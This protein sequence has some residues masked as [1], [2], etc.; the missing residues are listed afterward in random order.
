MCSYISLMQ[1]GTVILVSPMFS[2]IIIIVIFNIYQSVL[3]EFSCRT[4]KK[5]T[6]IF[7]VSFPCNG[8]HSS[9]NPFLKKNE[10]N[11]DNIKYTVYR[12][13]FAP[14]YSLRIL[15][16]DRVNRAKIKKFGEYFPAC[17]LLLNHS[18]RHSVFYNNV[19][20]SCSQCIHKNVSRKM[21]YRF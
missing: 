6:W 1:I 4:K 7:G 18:H 5:I 2:P 19:F 9:P 11:Y 8:H 10:I 14:W 21:Y 3:R 12:D 17:S 13:I 15:L 16:S 20:I